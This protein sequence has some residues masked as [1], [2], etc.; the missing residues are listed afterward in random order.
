MNVFVPVLLGSA[1]RRQAQTLCIQMNR[2][3]V[4]M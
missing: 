4:M 3:L 1:E 2:G